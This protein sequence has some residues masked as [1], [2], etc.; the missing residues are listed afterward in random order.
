MV[1]DPDPSPAEPPPT[2]VPTPPP[3]PAEPAT[4]ATIEAPP[5]SGFFEYEGDRRDD[6]FNLKPRDDR[7]TQIPEEQRKIH[8]EVYA[9]RNVL[10]LLR[11]NGVFGPSA[12]YSAGGVYK[13][14]IDRVVQ[15]GWAGCVARKAD[16]LLAAA[17]LEQIRGDVVRREGRPLVYRYL[18]LLAAWVSGGLAVGLIALVF[19]KYVSP[20]IAPYAFVLIGAMVGT[21]LSVAA[22]RREV[23]FESIQDFLR[24]H[25]EPFIR[26]LYVAL[27]AQV[28]ALL[29]EF[30]FVNLTIGSADLS[31][32][33]TSPGLALVLGLIAGIG[34]RTVS[35]QVIQKVE[36]ALAPGGAEVK[37]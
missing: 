21:W 13:E 36:K 20:R 16:L 10:M 37:R 19:A 8:D 17:A 27:L 12:T 9:A 32:F 25:Y 1:D 33:T 15:A 11:E 31:T 28:V 4:P 3:P 29:V 18:A 30:K 5:P 22:R 14:F 34:E 35:V 24:L 2:G 23:A 6:T 26:V 7:T